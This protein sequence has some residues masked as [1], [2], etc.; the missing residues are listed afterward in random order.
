MTVTN[1][2]GYHSDDTIAVI[3]SDTAAVAPRRGAPRRRSADRDPTGPHLL[4]GAHRP[5]RG[6][7]RDDLGHQP[8]RAGHRAAGRPPHQRPV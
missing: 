4:I 7:G 3:S 6:V 1:A 2:A 5:G 8:D